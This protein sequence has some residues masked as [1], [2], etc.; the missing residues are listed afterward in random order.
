MR[1]SAWAFACAVVV[2]PGVSASQGLDPSPD[3]WLVPPEASAR[4]NPLQAS[5]AA[6]ADARRLWA[7]HCHTCHGDE[8]RGDGPSA[9]LHAER[10]GQK[11]RDLTDPAVQENLT[12]GDIFWRVTHGIIEGDNIIMPA[13]GDKL[14][15]DEHRW[16]LV[17]M[18]REVGRAARERGN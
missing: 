5:E 12:D 15:A 11:P 18:V 1:G 16:K 10:H 3:P 9:R 17:L 13:Y 8:G 6:I 2:G 4:E 7:R 14:P